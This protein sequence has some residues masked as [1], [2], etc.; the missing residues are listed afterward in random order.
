MLLLWFELAA[1]ALLM[2]LLIWLC[3]RR[4]KR[5]AREMSPLG[6]GHGFDAM[7]VQAR[8]QAVRQD[9]TT[10]SASRY[11]QNPNHDLIAMAVRR[12]LAKLS[13]FRSAAASHTEAGERDCQEGG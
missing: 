2:G 3:R 7:P 4:A 1:L 8:L 9:Y 5:V 6:P 10:I 12:S 11:R 13:Y